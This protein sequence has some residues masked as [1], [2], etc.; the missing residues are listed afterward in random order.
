MDNSENRLKYLLGRWLGEGCTPEELQ[1]LWQQI[2]VLGDDGPMQ[3]ELDNLWQ[4]TAAMS[5]KAPPRGWANT[6]ERIYHDADRA[7]RE[8]TAISMRRKRIT[9]WAAAASVVLLLATGS[10]FL[11]FNKHSGS[12]QTIPVR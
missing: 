4:T 5:D 1:E 10:Y 9:R 2:R 12:P 11:F 8:Q 3:E 7:I 6:L